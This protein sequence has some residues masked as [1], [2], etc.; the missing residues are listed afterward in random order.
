MLYNDCEKPA[1]AHRTFPRQGVGGRKGETLQFPTP[2]QMLRRINGRSALED[3]MTIHQVAINCCIPYIW[4]ETD[5]HE[6]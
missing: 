4:P 1:H 3:R 6:F 5:A 2:N